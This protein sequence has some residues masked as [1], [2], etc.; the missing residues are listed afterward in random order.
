[1]LVTLLYGPN[2]GQ[3]RHIERNQL[4]QLLLD[5]NLIEIVAAPA[6]PA[7]STVP[8]FFVGPSAATGN[9]GIHVKLPSGEQR[10]TYNVRSKK[11]AEAVLGA[12]EL[13]QS[14]WDSYAAHTNA[15][16]DQDYLADQ[17]ARQVQNNRW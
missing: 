14:V 7:P 11:A 17:A 6:P 5:L 12:G 8:V 9:I 13:P 4:S 2:C 16:K 3:Q 10:S 1:M 15:G